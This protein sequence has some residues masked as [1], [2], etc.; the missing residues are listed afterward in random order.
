MLSW[1]SCTV[2]STYT[3]LFRVRALCTYNLGRWAGSDLC[4]CD[5]V[6]LDL[7]LKVL[8]ANERMSTNHVYC[9]KKRQPSKFLWTSEIRS[10]V[11]NSGRPPSS[12]Y[13]QMYAKV[14]F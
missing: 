11:D 2:L 8:I 13:L 4:R 12:M 3:P 6:Y 7:D 14:I 1:L 5:D 10:F 9:F